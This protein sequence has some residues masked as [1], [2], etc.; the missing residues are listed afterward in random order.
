[1]LLPVSHLLM[2]LGERHLRIL[3]RILHTSHR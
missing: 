1:M 2:V 3:L